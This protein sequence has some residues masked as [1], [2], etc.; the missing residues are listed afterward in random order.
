[1]IECVPNLSEGRNAETIDRASA[2]ITSHGARLLDVH[3]DPDHHR[4]VLTV[5]GSQEAVAGG[6]LGLVETV[7]PLIDLKQH[8]GVH[9]RMG[10]VDVVPFVPLEGETMDDAVAVARRVGREIGEG[11][12]IPVYL[13]EAAASR[14]ERV[15]L[16]AVRRG[17][18]RGVGER[19]GTPDGAPDFGPSEVHP[20]AGAVAVGARRFLVAYNINLTTSDVGAAK[21]IAASI[22]AAGGGLPGVKALGLRLAGRRL[23]QVSMNL[24]DVEATTM[25]TVFR[26]VAAAAHRLGVAVLESEIV[27]L[28]PRAAFGDATAE[29]LKLS[30]PLAALTLEDR[31]EAAG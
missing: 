2:A 7:L 4:S 9:P 13:Y 24:T 11:L 8:E 26:R 28:V 15:N 12:R 29:E 16:A 27:G 18:L 30:K 6:I 20:T 19:I 3:V 1:M 17:G 22:R 23:A 25:A 31:I 14:P 10:A 5:V 21:A